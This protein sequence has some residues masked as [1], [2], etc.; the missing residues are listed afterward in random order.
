MSFIEKFLRRFFLT[1]NSW[2]EIRFFCIAWLLLMVM[3][4]IES[5]SGNRL[6]F[7]L[8]ALFALSGFAATFAKREFTSLEVNLGV[9]RTTLLVISL[10]M[11]VGFLILNE[12][13]NASSGWYVI[14]RDFLIIRMLVFLLLFGIQR[15]WWTDRLKFL[16]TPINTQLSLR[17]WVFVVGIPFAYFMYIF[18]K[19]INVLPIS[20]AIWLGYLLIDFFETYY[21]T[22]S[23]SRS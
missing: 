9:E 13:G 4:A 2:N 20:Q 3:F 5:E 7:V 15:Y 6:F 1:L 21:L 10:F 22:L 11:T 19:D 8:P 17:T 16:E 18:S 12:A 14:T 23:K